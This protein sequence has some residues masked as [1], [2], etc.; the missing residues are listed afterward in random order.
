M[1]STSWLRRYSTASTWVLPRFPVET[2]SAPPRCSVNNSATVFGSRCIPVP[3][4][5]PA[6]GRVESNSSAIPPSRRQ[7]S[8]TQSIRVPTTYS[9]CG[10]SAWLQDSHFAAAA[11]AE[12]FRVAA[13][14]MA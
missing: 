14:P 4:R 8:I 11:Q 6:K 5:L 12:S 1:T 13:G 9:L 3:M 2:T 7:L 10:F